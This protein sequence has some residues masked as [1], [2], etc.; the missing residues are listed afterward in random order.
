MRKKTDYIKQ[1]QN[2]KLLPCEFIQLKLLMPCCT[3]EVTP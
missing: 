2:A 3:A 1:I